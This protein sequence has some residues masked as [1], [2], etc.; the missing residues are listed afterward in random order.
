M[1]VL[2]HSPHRCPQI[3]KVG[4]FA[5]SLC[6]CIPWASQSHS[7]THSSLR[8]LHVVTIGN[9]PS[10]DTALSVYRVCVCVCVHA[11]DCMCVCVCMSLCVGGIGDTSVLYTSMKSSSRCASGKAWSS[12]DWLYLGTSC[13][14]YM[15]VC[16][17][18]CV[19]E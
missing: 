18:V 17:C 8:K 1:S 11:C 5:L 10:N 16:V 6:C 13:C 7:P 14:V 12:H 4:L 3:Y 19:C 2:P 9:T 15:C